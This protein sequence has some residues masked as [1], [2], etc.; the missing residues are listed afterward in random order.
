M[1]LLPILLFIL[2]I[3][4]I[5][6]GWRWQN[7]SNEE[8][9]TALKG[10]AYLKNDIIQVQ[11]Q[12]NELEGKLLQFKELDLQRSE[13]IVND[14]E[15]ETKQ[16]EPCQKTEHYPLLPPKYQEILEMAAN[17][18]R[19]PEIAQSLVLSQDAVR[20]VLR[21]HPDGGNAR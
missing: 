1:G 10:L 14:K 18:C 20:M 19:I 11:D 2:G 12:V 4:F 7:P 13:Q 5:F 16:T 8:A 9:L 21:M 6:L 3:G 15:N 17:G